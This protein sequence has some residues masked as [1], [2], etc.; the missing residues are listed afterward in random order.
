MRVP[1]S[2]PVRRALAGVALLAL[3]SLVA[4][5][6]V[7]THRDLRGSAGA[8]YSHCELC[9]TLH[10]SVLNTAGVTVSFSAAAEPLKS[11]AVADLHSRVLLSNL[12]IRPPPAA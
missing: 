5:D 11:V 10:A 1:V 3:V 4:L 12:S 9:L 2:N 7:H 6:A 8:P